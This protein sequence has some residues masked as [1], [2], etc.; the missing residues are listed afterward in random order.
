[1]T[2]MKL[3]YLYI[4]T[5]I[6]ILGSCTK[7]FD[8]IENPNSSTIVPPSVLFTGVSRSAF[9]GLAEAGQQAAQFYVSYNGG[10]LD[11]ITYYFQRN[12]FSEYSHLRNVE[13]LRI[14]AESQDA[15]AYYLGLA[16]FLKAYLF[17]QLTQKVGDIPYSEALLAKDGIVSPKY[18]SQK[19]IYMNV[20][21]ELEEANELIPA[22]GTV[23][24]D[25]IF[26][27]SLLKWK[28]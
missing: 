11:E 24:G 2:I 12:S 4:S 13:R 20:L 22:T 8:D 18:D 7:G 17:V 9:G 10:A 5:L 28:K 14:E 23:V 1:H 3:K 27:G 26:D 19:N 25:I 6:L 16:K 15:P 21:K